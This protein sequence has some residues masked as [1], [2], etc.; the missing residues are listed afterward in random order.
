MQLPEAL[1]YQLAFG[2]VRGAIL[3]ELAHSDDGISG[4]EL[5]DR[6]YGRRKPAAPR[7]TIG[8]H[9]AHLRR[10]LKP[11]GITIKSRVNGISGYRLEKETLT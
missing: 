5:V 1:L 7:A 4:T 2:T 8:V 9:I 6:V 10:I 3:Q 11:H